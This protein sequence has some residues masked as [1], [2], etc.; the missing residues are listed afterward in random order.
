MNK[1]LLTLIFV[2]SCFIGFTQNFKG[3][4]K[5]YFIDNSTSR[6]SWGG[7][8]CDYVLD[9]DING[10]EVTGYSYT[11][12]SSDG[13]KYYTICTL[14]GTADKKNK[15]IEI[16]EIARTKTNVPVNISNSFQL[17]KLVWRKEGDNEILEGTWKPAPGQDISNTGY[18]TTVL[19][20][21]QLTEISPLAKKINNKKDPESVTTKPAF[22]NP[23][24]AKKPATK[25]PVV[26]ATPANK[27][28]PTT[29]VV[30]KQKNMV[31]NKPTT[32][33]KNTITTKAAVTQPTNNTEPTT[34]IAVNTP[35]PTTPTT[36]IP[37]GFEKR[38]TNV[39]QTVIVENPTVKIELY[40]NGEVDGDSVS[41][42]YNGKVL[43]AHKRLTQNAIMI[44]LP[45]NNDEVNELVMYA[46]NLGTLPP[47]TALMIVTDGKK[48]YE[49]RITSDLQKSGTI[50][51]VHK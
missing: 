34:P 16:S 22:T 45:V 12:F 6:F 26:A 39:L 48:R 17:H 50:R 41:L 33:A 37:P 11:Y 29:P 9:I 2:G 30:T 35:K 19:T 4:W 32:T 15:T 36:V 47:N 28:K 10:K 42:F 49:V 43:L 23:T 40:D 18:G 8:K 7:D 13:I 14:K 1:F 46:D 3:Q 51:F 24:V 21:R 44:D 20:K 5:G 31:V 25:A 38:N 27:V